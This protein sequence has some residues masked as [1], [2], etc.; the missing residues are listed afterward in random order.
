MIKLKLKQKK[1]PKQDIIIEEN[2]IF[3]DVKGF[4]PFYEV[5]NFGVVRSKERTVI[6]KD[7]KLKPIKSRYLRPGNNGSGYLFVQLWVDNIPYRRYV[8]RIVAETFIPNPSN[9]EE[10]NHIDG[11]KSNNAVS[12]LEWC[13]RLYNERT[14]ERIIENYHS[15]KVY[16]VDKDG[17]ILNTFASMKQC[18]R[19]LKHTFKTVKDL[20]NSGEYINK[21][22][23]T[24]KLVTNDIT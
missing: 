20:I 11:D 14:K 23:K 10:V 12:N 13:N 15:I 19:E 17:T 1:T 5:S 21:N 9:L 4:E 2:S 8:H 7:G 22:F 6:C 3:K 16:Q 18:C 24:Y